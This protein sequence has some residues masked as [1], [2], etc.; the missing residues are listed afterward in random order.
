MGFDLFPMILTSFKI[1]PVSI[2]GSKN[3]RCPSCSVLLLDVA[4]LV[5]KSS[6]YSLDLWVSLEVVSPGVLVCVCS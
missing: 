3:T 4:I 1:G 5:Y 6:L 2:Q